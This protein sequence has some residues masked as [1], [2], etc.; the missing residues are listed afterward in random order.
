[1]AADPKMN[2]A[3]HRGVH[4]PAGC[5]ADRAE[6]VVPHECSGL[7]LDQV[8]TRLLPG[9][10]RRNTRKS[11]EHVLVLVDGQRQKPGSRVRAG[12]RVTVRPRENW[13]RKPVV[14][15]L[16]SGDVT[17]A[18]QNDDFAA[19]VKPAGV[20]SQ[21]MAD[22]GGIS[23]EAVLPALFPDN[24]VVLLNRLDLPVSGVLLAALHSEAAESYGAWQNQ[25]IVRKHYLAVVSG[26]VSAAMEIRSALDTAKRRKVRV[27]SHEEPDALRW[28]RVFP[29]PYHEA[30][31]ESLVR[32]EILKGRRHQIR[33]H[34]AAAGHPVRSDPVY[35]AGP[36]RGWINLHHCGVSLPGFD[37]WNFPGWTGWE[38]W[39]SELTAA[40]AGS[41]SSPG[42]WQNPGR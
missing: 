36:D 23:I 16:E 17:V 32:V 26:Q 41:F 33:A 25:G 7:R 8:L 30:G 13:T 1:M 42:P 21:A 24:Q 5:L 6:F 27:L 9:L 11:W 37:A 20:H 31:D 14:K 40:F 19:L 34:L 4:Q 28:T 3:R 35:G 2:A 18:A 38:D 29:G 10:G 15:R 39:Q 12:Q 22:R